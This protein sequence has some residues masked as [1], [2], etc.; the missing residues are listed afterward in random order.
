MEATLKL[1][2]DK[3]GSAI[4]VIK[5]PLQCGDQAYDGKIDRNSGSGSSGDEEKFVPLR[6]LRPTITETGELTI[7]FNKPILKPWIKIDK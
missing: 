5:V 1:S 4:D 6:M 7:K 2:S 3:L